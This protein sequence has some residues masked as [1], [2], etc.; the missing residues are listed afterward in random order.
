MRL[1][2]PYYFGKILYRVGRLLM[3]DKNRLYLIIGIVVAVLFLA[4][5]FSGT[6]RDV[7]K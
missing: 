1:S 3:K 4:G 6:L 2:F 7:L 5:T